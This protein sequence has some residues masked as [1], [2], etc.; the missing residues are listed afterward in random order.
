[1]FPRGGLVRGP[2]GALYGTT[3]R[4]GQMGFG[5]IFRYG[6]RLGDITDVRVSGQTA[7]NLACVGVPG[8]NYVLERSVDLSSSNW[9]AIASTNAPANGQFTIL[10]ALFSSGS[11]QAFYRLRH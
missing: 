2:D 1:M 9:K 3:D 6:P 7:L 4:G 10:D 5:T 11:Q 8:T